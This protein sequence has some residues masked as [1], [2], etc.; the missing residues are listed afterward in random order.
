M[1]TVDIKHAY[2]SIALEDE[3]KHLTSFYVPNSD[4]RGRYVYNSINMGLSDSQSS[5]L[6]LIEMCLGDLLSDPI[7]R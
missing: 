3:S 5:F 2:W 4:C 7:C 1:S 6:K